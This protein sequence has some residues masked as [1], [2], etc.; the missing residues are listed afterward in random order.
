MAK[1][2]GEFPERSPEAETATS[3]AHTPRLGLGVIFRWFWP[4]TRPYR[5]RLLISMILVCVGPFVDTAQIW[6][7][8]LLIDDVLAPRNF[9]AFPPLAVAYLGIAVIQGVGSFSDE[10][11]AAPDARAVDR[12]AA[13]AGRRPMGS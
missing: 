1:R 8:K 10:V 4:A 9:H 11:P 3:G 5:G 13:F 6:M 7:F 2:Q 12:L